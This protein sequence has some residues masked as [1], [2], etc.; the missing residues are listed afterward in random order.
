ML[1]QS[2][3]SRTGARILV[4]ALE[5]HGLAH[6]FGVPGESYLAVL[7]ALSDSK[8]DFT[9]CRQESGAAFMA[10][11]AGKL[12]GKPGLCFVTRGPGMTNASAGIHV[13]QQDSTPMILIAGQIP[14]NFRHREAFQEVDVRAVFGTMA[15]WVVEIDDPARIPEFAARAV[16]IATQGRPGPVVMTLPEDMLIEEAV[17]EDLAA[18]EPVEIAPSVADMAR[19]QKLLSEAKKPFIVVGGS[20]WNQAAVDS[21]TR[22]AERFDIPVGA[23]FRRQMLF[24]NQHDCYAGDVGTGPNPKLA[25]RVKD[26]DL[27]LAFG[28]RLS[29]WP[30]QGY[31]L[32]TAPDPGRNFVHVHAGIEELGRVFQPTLAINATPVAFAAALESVQPPSEIPWREWRKSTRDDYLAWSEPLPKIPG[33]VQMSTIVDWLRKNLPADTVMCSGAGNFSI[34]LHRFYRHPKFGTQLAPISGTMG[35]GVPAAVAAAKLDPKRTVLC[36]AGDGDFLM[37][38]QELATAMQYGLAPKIFVIDNGTYGTI[39]MHQEREYPGRVFGTDLR[40][41]DFAM[42]ARSF[43]AD[44]FTIDD[45]KDAVPVME[46]AFASKKAAVVHVKIATDAITPTTTLT[47]LREKALKKG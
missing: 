45:N 23:S 8:I 6:A 30:T 19:L 36:F 25:Q 2:N 31:T 37:T 5:A 44:G 13:A 17:T 28:A 7:D 20:R 9:I 26:A 39:R 24:P 16:R 14:R 11:A 18:F 34:W 35:Y 15:K 29:E 10:E 1:K 38:G 21:L 12:T 43:G 27:V 32:V 47:A 3:R 40:N 46:K 22:F 4:D 42:F 33:N 41:P